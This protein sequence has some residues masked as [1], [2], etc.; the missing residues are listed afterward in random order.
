LEQEILN[1]PLQCGWQSE[2]NLWGVTFHHSGIIEL[3]LPPLL[4]WHPDF[5]S[6]VIVYHL[7]MEKYKSPSTVRLELK[8]SFRDNIHFLKIEDFKFFSSMRFM[9]QF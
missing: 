7:G 3:N 5:N 2:F 4:G 6:G 1:L 9:A 8:I